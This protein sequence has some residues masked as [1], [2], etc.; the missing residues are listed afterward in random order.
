MTE[1]RTNSKD[2]NERITLSV[3]DKTYHGNDN[4]IFTAE[5]ISYKD[6][7]KVL[8]SHNYSPII[9]KEGKRESSNFDYA[10]GFVV[11]IDSGMTIEEAEQLLQSKKLNYILITSKSHST[12][13]NKF[14]IL[15]PFNRKIKTLNNYQT[16]VS[17]IINDLFPKSDQRVT[18]GGRFIFGSPE[19]AYCSSRFESGS[20]DIETLISKSKKESPKPIRV[21]D[22]WDSQLKVKLVDGSEV[23][24]ESLTTKEIIYCPFHD[25]QTASAFFD[26]SESSGNHYINCSSCGKT[27]WKV[28]S[29]SSEEELCTSF[30]SHETSIYESKIVG[31]EFSIKKI[32]KEKFL[33]LVGYD[34][35][36]KSEQHEIFSHV[37]KNKHIHTIKRIDY[38]SDISINESN[39]TFDP[40]EGIFSVSIKPQKYGGIKDNDFIEKYLESVFGLHKPFIKEWLAVYFHSNYR[41]LPFIILTGSRGSG[42]NT[43]AES[44]FDVFPALSVITKALEGNFN[45]SAEKKLVIIDES[46]SNG[47]I[48]YQTLKK[49]SGQNMIEV[50][51]K[52]LPEYSVKNNMNMIILSNNDLP[53]FVEREE[54]PSDEN[55]N[56]FFVYKVP[57]FTGIIDPD[58]KKKINDRMF[59]YINTELKQVFKRLNFMGKRYS[60]TTPI[61]DE[62]KNLFADNVTELDACTDML[63]RRILENIDTNMYSEMD[64]VKKGFLPSSFVELF[65]FNSR[66]SNNQIIKNMKESG[67]LKRGSAVRKQINSKR[68]YG[69]EIDDRLM[70]EINNVTQPNQPAPQP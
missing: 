41:K 14:H 42:K 60:V 15:L 12:E 36:Q 61:T 23:L 63:I 16:T 7:P 34:H 59:N 29:P 1:L 52:Y 69:Y 64:L 31:D 44:I 11:D 35:K 28:I 51:K 48:Q 49:L 58:F 43:F 22:A 9:W 47:K 26:Y 38:Q 55:N 68:V 3:K 18:D 54:L 37:V 39:Y 70:Q 21:P 46:L 62:E 53:I 8:T 13:K 5:E 32:G 4:V 50:N 45:P 65:N 27:F 24:A 56:Q 57:K 67:Y 66:I 19:D 2:A 25:D 17:G 30:W 40:A 10:T 20:A 6:L 33:I